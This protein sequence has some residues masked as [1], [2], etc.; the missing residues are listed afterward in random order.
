MCGKIEDCLRKKV[1]LL[2]DYE[3]IERTDKT[4]IM[5]ENQI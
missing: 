4:R 2:E 5:G 1:I 3:N